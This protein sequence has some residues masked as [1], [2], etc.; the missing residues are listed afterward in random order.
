MNKRTKNS[1]TASLFLST[2]VLGVYASKGY[3]SADELTNNPS[4][5]VVSETS[6]TGVDT[7]STA[8]AKITSTVDATPTVEVAPTAEVAPTTEVAPTNNVVST[9]PTVAEASTNKVTS[10]AE[11]TPTTEVEPSVAETSKAEK[12]TKA[13]E[14]PKAEEKP[15]ETV[16]TN[17]EENPSTG[18]ILKSEDSSTSKDEE[19][20]STSET[21]SSDETPKASTPTFNFTLGGRDESV[22]DT[23][24]KIDLGEEVSFEN[25]TK[26]TDVTYKQVTSNGVTFDLTKNKV[27]PI[28][29]KLIAVYK[30]DK[31]KEQEVTVAE[32]TGTKVYN[33]GLSYSNTGNSVTYTFDLNQ[34]LEKDSYQ[35]KYR[36]LVDGVEVQEF[37]TTEDEITGTL[38]LINNLS[39]GTHVVEIVG[40]SKFGVV[41]SG[42][43]T[44]IV[45]AESVPTPSPAPLPN[46]DTQPGTATDGDVP[47]N[48]VPGYDS[49]APKVNPTDNST[50]TPTVN[51]TVNPTVT[52][53]GGGGASVVTPERDN[54]GV[55]AP[56][57]PTTTK[58]VDV[59]PTP[60]PEPVKEPVRGVSDV[61]VGGVSIYGEAPKSSGVATNGDTTTFTD[62][63]KVDVRV[64]LDTS[65]IDSS[66]TVLKLVGREQGEIGASQ[67]VE[68]KDGA[69]KIKGVAKDDF[70]T[71]TIK[72]YDKNG[73][74]VTDTVE[75]FSVNKGGSKY[76][77]S[78]K[79]LAGSSVKNLNSNL[80][81][82]E[83]NVDKIKSDKT[84]I[85]V[86][87]DGKL[88]EL[89]KDAIK[90]SRSGGVSGKWKYT[91]SINKN[92]FKAEGVYTI[93]VYSESETGVNYNSTKKTLQF[94]VDR[95]PAEIS[96]SG[97]RD[98]GR[99]KA[100]S[101]RIT[102][103]I[104]DIS[105]LKS[106]KAFLNG[107]EVELEY[108]S[109]TG[110]YYYE[111]KSSGKGKNEFVVEVEDAAGNVSTETVKGFYLSEDLAFS[112]FNDDNLY[113]LLGGIAAATGGFLGF[114]ALRRKRKLDEEDRLALEQAELLAAS[115]SS[116]GSET[117]GESPESSEER[118]NVDDILP[119]GEE[120]LSVST[121]EVQDTDLEGSQD[122]EDVEATDVLPEDEEFSEDDEATDVIPEDDEDSEDNEATDVI[123]DSEDE[124]SEDNQ[125]TDVIEDSSDEDELKT[126]VID[127]D[128]SEDSE[129]TD[130]VED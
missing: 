40:Q 104:R 32:I 112:I 47:Y 21:P 60:Q 52:P 74:L 4:T 28:T 59:D 37:D 123:E 50:V 56:T 8:V 66:R 91:Y 23:P 114:L 93:E 92:K 126:D 117:V 9:T 35:S 68:L 20:S 2:A 95:T 3:V 15:K 67:F 24:S 80:K 102:I 55:L 34:L 107:K 13:E 49:T 58:P 130:I 6:N 36:V 27:K 120:I 46:S 115:A 121:E 109:E 105:E 79:G 29:S 25:N 12:E 57:T 48:P 108:D 106:V 19:S 129:P 84:T 88:V 90:V 86:F 14:S 119:A 54:T 99:Y 42:K 65:V 53:A 62:P 94:T 85:K 30:D 44:A 113:W 116:S 83:T 110:L 31:G 11:A 78:N 75:T 81:I 103:D 71:L 18:E 43:D 64:Q 124:D 100:S 45:P 39:E 82:E 87:L 125:K 5:S 111:M 26:H 97:I 22:T 41:V 1:L 69:Y 63:K 10:S 17:A 118:F 89:P 101:K 128:S 70:Y 77:I 96:I 76:S 51:P 72:A 61:R 16:I 33:L 98:G 7:G 38:N 73:N 127:E 122:A